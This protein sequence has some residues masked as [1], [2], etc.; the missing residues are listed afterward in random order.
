MRLRHKEAPPPQL[1]PCFAAPVGKKVPDHGNWT[2]QRVDDAFW[3]PPTYDARNISD[4][5]QRR[6][7]PGEF[8]AK[9]VVPLQE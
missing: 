9:H 6:G 2:P 5:H 3:G 8:E 7:R 4:Y 1:T